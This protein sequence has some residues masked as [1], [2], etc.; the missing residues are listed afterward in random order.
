MGTVYFNLLLERVVRF[1]KYGWFQLIKWG[2]FK[3]GVLPQ[4]FST[5]FVDELKVGDS[6]SVD[7]R[8]QESTKIKICR[9]PETNFFSHFS[10][11]R[12]LTKH[13]KSVDRL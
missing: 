12:V 7:Q 5:E 6:E 8:N 1:G 11:S 13:L 3:L 9:L 2:L 10:S 4:F